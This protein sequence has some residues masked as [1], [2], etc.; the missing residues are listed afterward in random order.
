MEVKDVTLSEQRPTTLLLPKHA[1]YIEKWSKSTSSY[2]YIMSEH[3]RMSGLYWCVTAM[4]LMHERDRL[5][6]QGILQLVEACFNE[7][8]DGG[9]SASPEHDSHLL[10]TLSAVQVLVTFDAL[11]DRHTQAVVRY[12]KTLQLA[13]GSFQGDKWGEIDTRFSF[14]ALL[15][16]SLLNAMEAVNVQQAAEYVLRCLNFDGG[17]GR[18]PGSESHAGQMYCCVGALALA[19]QLHRADA[20]LV[21]FYLCERQLK[22]GGFNGR[23]EKLPDVCYSWWVLSA[24]AMIGRLH[25]ISRAR[26]RDFI[27]AC[28]DAE[29]GGF[30]DRPG[31][32]VDPF[33]TIFGLAGL[34]LLK[35]PELKP[36]NA[37]YCMPD[38]IIQ[39]AVRNPP[40]IP[41]VTLTE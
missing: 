1:D 34:S 28:Q 31:D 37:I 23:P 4:D 2:E 25:W 24:L 32:M 16:L 27:L 41:P 14:C 38:E 6:K 18:V 39:R 35:Q 22:S 8:G 7:K 26:L 11:E 3:L 10:Y 33:H 17:F 30:A 21:G 5:D 13:D 20:D 40:Y 19:G 36:I 9:F 12:I 29:S 15:C